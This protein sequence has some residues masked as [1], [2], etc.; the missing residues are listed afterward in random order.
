[1]S[2]FGSQ[3]QTAVH[4]RLATAAALAACT[5]SDASGVLPTSTLGAKLVANSNGALTIDGVSAVVDDE[6]LVK[7]QS[8]TLQNGVYRVRSIGGTSSKWSLER[9]RLA[10]SSEQFLG[11]LV[12]IGSEGTANP[13]GVFLYSGVSNP[14]IGTTAITYAHTGA[15]LSGYATKTYVQDNASLFVSA[16]PTLSAIADGGSLTLTPL[17]GGGMSNVYGLTCSGTI[18]AFTVVVPDGVVDGQVLELV[19]THIITALTL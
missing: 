16:Q 14:V 6:V 1:M 15:D 13:S 2:N 7:D 3:E 5:Y 11:M 4:V 12:T 8:S 19:C 9:S 17:S 10:R 18:P